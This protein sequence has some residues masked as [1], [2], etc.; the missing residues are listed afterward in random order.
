MRGEDG[1]ENR[2]GRFLGIKKYHDWSSSIKEKKIQN[3]KR[4]DKKR[5]WG[6]SADYA[7]FAD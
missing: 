7:D 3:K 5:F 1:K 2:D 4:R 6:F